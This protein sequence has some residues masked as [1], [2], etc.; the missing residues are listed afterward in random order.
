MKRI[1]MFALL[2]VGLA[3]S[4]PMS[5]A[6]DKKDKEAVK[7][8]LQV[9]QEYI[10]SWTGNG[11]AKE[12]KPTTWK[13]TMNWGWNFKG[14]LGLS[15]E[16]DKSKNFTKGLLK[17]LPEK[18]TYQLALTDAAKEEVIYEGKIERKALV[19]KHEDSA[20]KDISSI[21]IST[22]NDGARMI[23]T[24]AVQ[25]KGK[26]LEK[27]LYT[28]QHTKEG[29]SLASAKKNECCVTGGLG[30]IAV[31]YAG[32]TYYVCCTGC[33]AAFDDDA[34]NIVAEYEKKSKKK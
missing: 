13:E 7:A 14:D 24:V 26:G 9:L 11:E 1:G 2:V 30:T 29:M 3:I 27:K 19:L 21:T 20:T 23:Y 10:G 17:Y 6:Q 4:S 31:S 5:I 34:K 8:G 18:K 15:V 16:F 28:V 32:K 33:K 25:P 22:N 12:G